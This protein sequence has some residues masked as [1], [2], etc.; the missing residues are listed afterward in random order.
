MDVGTSL[1]A[2]R[3]DRWGRDGARQ[4]HSDDCIPR[5]TKSQQL[6]ESCDQVRCHMTYTC[7]LIPRLVSVC[8]LLIS[9][10]ECYCFIMRIFHPRNVPA[11]G[12]SFTFVVHVHVHACMYVYM[13]MPLH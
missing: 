4:D 2:G 3:G 9:R 7:T 6:E 8:K 13:H 5:W 11:V 12:L 1:S 10:R